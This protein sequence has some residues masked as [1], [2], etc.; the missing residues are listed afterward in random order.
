[1]APVDP[2]TLPRPVL[3][4]I[5]RDL[6]KSAVESC[7]TQS[8]SVARKERAELNKFFAE[9]ASVARRVLLKRGAPTKDH[10]DEAEQLLADGKTMKE[11]CRALEK[12]TP[13]ERNALKTALRQRKY[14]KKT[15]AQNR[16]IS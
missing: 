5:I 2:K 8:S 14:R 9:I 1:M 10:L 15:S 12:K 3:L 7:G 13:A 11:V 4:D 6:A 16:Q